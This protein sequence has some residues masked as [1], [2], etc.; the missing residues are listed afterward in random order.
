MCLVLLAVEK[1]PNYK[2]VIAA[3]RDE[4]YDRSSSKAGFWKEA[5][6]ILAGRDLV[7]GGTWLGISKKGRIG[8]L[9]NYRDPQSRRQDAPSRGALVSGYLLGKQSP[10]QYL[11]EVREKAHLFNGFNL[12]VGNKDKIYYYSNRTGEI[13]KLPPGIHGLSNHLLNT[14]W[15]KVV[16]GKQGISRLMEDSGDVLVEK[17]FE[18]LKDTHVAADELLPNTGVGLDWERILSPIFITSPSYGTR[19]STLLLIGRNG[20]VSFLER[21]FNSKAE[22][23]SSVKFEFRIEA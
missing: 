2:L 22:C 21:S 16:R 10:V 13:S 14:P 4:Y 9:T 11:E 18:L 15:P 20:Y 1:H 7:G 19:S 23:I 12:V 5:P 6:E 8:L 17:L 3:N